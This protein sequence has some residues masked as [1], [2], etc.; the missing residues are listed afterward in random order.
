LPEA[1]FSCSLTRAIPN[2][3]AATGEDG[4]KGVAMRRYL[5][6][7]R[8]QRGQVFALTALGMVGICGIAGF[9]IDTGTWYRAHRAQQAIADAS[10]LAAAADLP[11][12][13]SQATSDAITYASKNGGSL[14]NADI[15]YS[16]TYQP[17]DTVTVHTSSTAPAYFLKVLGI[18]SASV[19]ASATAT[20]V[21][22]GS[23]WGSAPFAVYYTQRELSGTGCP[24]FNVQTTLQ[25]GKVGPGGFQI[26][27]IDGSQGGSGQTILADWITN[28]CNCSTD[29]PN[30]LF[31]DAGAKFNSSEVNTALTQRLN[32]TLLFPVYDQTRGTG[33]GLQY[34]VIAFV[35]FHITDFKF[36]GSNNGSIDGY[37]VQTM[38]KGGGTTNPPGRYSA[39]TT[40]LVG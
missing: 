24:C 3:C 6:K 9:A 8:A 33:T 1:A 18:S 14:A 21:P 23:A 4:V 10:A 27:N 19:G 35:G 11:N 26:I 25:Y 17:N 31:N 13:T 20:A 22:L 38:W 36:Q 39:T 32:S 30:W 7:F 28:G 12:D 5:G 2:A 37:F 15:A 16:T 29:T 40:Q 34:H